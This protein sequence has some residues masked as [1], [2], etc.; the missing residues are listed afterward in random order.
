[1]RN[2]LEL[3]ESSRHSSPQ[4]ESNIKHPNINIYQLY[5][6]G[7]SEVNSNCNSL[8]NVSN[9]NKDIQDKTKLL[10][11]KADFKLNIDEA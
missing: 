9:Q 7:T 10:I 11:S 1:L 5:Q 6:N 4:Q 2:S 3:Y 8:S